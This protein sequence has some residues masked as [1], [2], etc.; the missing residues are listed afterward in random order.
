MSD[1]EE[2]TRRSSLNETELLEREVEQFRTQFAALEAALSKVIVGNK[3]HS[4]AF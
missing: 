1:F 4:G 2:H 3:R